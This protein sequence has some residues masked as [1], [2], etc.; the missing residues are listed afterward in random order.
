[1]RGILVLVAA[2]GLVACDGDGTVLEAE[3]SVAVGDAARPVTWED[4]LNAPLTDPCDGLHPSGHLSDGVMA[5]EPGMGE[6]RVRAQ[7][8]EDPHIAFGD[9]TG[10]GIDDAVVNV[11]CTTGGNMGR[12]ALQFYTDGDT[13]VTELLSQGDEDHRS[14]GMTGIEIIDQKVHLTFAHFAPEDPNCCPSLEDTQV[15][16]WDGRD[17]ILG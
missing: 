12:S 4:V 1:M 15:W 10:D 16:I 8:P 11:I 7:S 13:W 6:V 3:P 2:C 17:L 5:G 9:F 14:G